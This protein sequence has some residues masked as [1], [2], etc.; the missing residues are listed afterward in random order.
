MK[1]FRRVSFAAVTLLVVALAVAGLGNAAATTPQIRNVIVMV[2]DGMGI[3]AITLGR[4]AIVGQEGRLAFETFPV[5]GLLSTYSANGIVTD[6][7]A[8][9]T[10]LAT[11]YKTY[12]GVIAMA[13]RQAAQG[14]TE[15]YPVKTLLEA[16]QEAGKAVALVSTNTVYDATPAAF[17]SHWG[18]RG[19]SDEIAAQIFDKKI[20]VI[21]GGGKDRFLPKGVD[22]GKR[23]DGR[24]LIAEA[25]KAGY[26]VVGNASELKSATGKARILGLFTPS[27]MNYVK[28]RQFLGAPEPSLKEMTGVTLVALSQNKKGFFAM[29]EGARVDHAAHAVDIP[30]VVAEMREFN[31]AVQAVLDFAKKDGHTLVIVTADHDTMGLS[32]SESVNYDMLARVKVSPEFMGL[33]MARDANKVFTAESIRQVFAEYAGINDLTEAE[34]AIVQS[35]SSKAAYQVGYEIGSIIAA[36]ANVGS[37]LSSVRAIGDTGGH[38]ANLVALYAFG[39]NAARFAGMRDNTEVAKIIA[40]VFGLKL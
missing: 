10:A 16:S 35:V 5:T 9:G 12:N 33:K 4:N 26:T 23:A 31:D 8:A 36:R 1:I 40:A 32:V 11:G 17:G 2:G 38:T 21:L 18:T 24:D 13:P 15:F 3:G 14:G 34:V 19:G 6:S 28:D 22:V 20:D 29:I 39:P 7:A 25:K 27:Y 37:L 30:G